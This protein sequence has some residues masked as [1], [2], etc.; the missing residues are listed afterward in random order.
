MSPLKVLGV[1]K[2]RCEYGR[3]D[4]RVGWQVTLLPLLTLIAWDV[5]PEAP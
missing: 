3:D 1:V 2:E 5:S 4:L